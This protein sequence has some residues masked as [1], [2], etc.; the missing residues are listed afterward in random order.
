MT[1]EE[2]MMASSSPKKEKFKTP[3]AQ[4]IVGGERERP[5]F[6]ILFF[7]PNSKE[8]HIGFSSFSLEYVF[9]WLDEEF[10][11][12]EDENFAISALRPVS[13]EQVEKV[14]KG[15]WIGNDGE[16][17]G[18]IDGVPIKSATCS[19]CGHWLTASDEYDCEGHFCPACGKAMTDEAVQMVME[20][21]E[22]LKD[23]S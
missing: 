19:S 23:E 8:F 4:L 1:R 6:S 9:N 10:E 15:E 13:R 3:F 22:A 7:D 20:R 21:L 16:K 12:V 14:C 2:A 17:V 11:V 18:T 5:C